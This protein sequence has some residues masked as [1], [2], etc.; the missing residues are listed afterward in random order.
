MNCPNCGGLVDLEKKYCEYCDTTFTDKELGLADDAVHKEAEKEA[1]KPAEP[2]RKKTM[3]EQKQEELAKEKANR[4]S[5]PVDTSS[6]EIATGAAVMGIM[7]LFS[8]VR[9]FFHNLKR[10]VCLLLLIALEVGFAFLMIS[11]KVTELMTGEIEGFVAVNVLILA[12]AL[13][14][15]LISRMGR[16][17]AGN[18]VVAVVNCLAVIWV[19]VYPLITSNFAGQTPQSVAIFAVVEIAVLGLSVLLSHIIYRR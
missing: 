13:L 5:Q 1:P 8:G 12:N 15:G 18:G 10:T 2:E 11:G 7:S 3:T 6:R 9:R 14:A 4:K 17:R 16:I 19:Y